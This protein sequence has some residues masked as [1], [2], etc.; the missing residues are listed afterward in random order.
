MR[1]VAMAEHRL[2]FVVFASKIPAQSIG[3]AEKGDL[4]TT[5]VLTHRGADPIRASRFARDRSGAIRGG[6]GGLPTAG[7]ANGRPRL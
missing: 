5:A 3:H 7:A 1:K 4:S 2:L 6:F